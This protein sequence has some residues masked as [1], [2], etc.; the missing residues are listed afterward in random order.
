[1][2]SDK[3]SNDMTQSK[4]ETGIRGLTISR[5]PSLNKFDNLVTSNYIQVHIKNDYLRDSN[6]RSLEGME[7]NGRTTPSM[8]HSPHEKNYFDSNVYMSKHEDFQMFLNNVSS[9]DEN[10]FSLD[11]INNLINR[12]NDGDY[13]VYG[14]LN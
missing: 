7:T 12:E 11:D 2:H 9:G 8:K 6:S 4:I 13:D 1:V 3:G 10:N 14:Y 5:V